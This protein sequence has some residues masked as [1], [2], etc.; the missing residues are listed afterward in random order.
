K[1]EALQNSPD[2]PETAQDV[3]ADQ[4]RMLDAPPRVRELALVLVYN[5]DDDGYLPPHR[6]VAPLLAAMD[7]SGNLTTPLA[8][9]VAAGVGVAAVKVPESRRGVSPEQIAEAVDSRER[10]ILEAQDVLSRILRIRSAPGG[11]RL[12]NRE[13]TLRYPLVD[14]LDREQGD[15]TVE[16]AE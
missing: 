11:E 10:V 14:V 4:L 8:D 2:R 1:Y 7:E 12:T 6:F 3:L 9:A 5:L 13:L 16:E 15:W